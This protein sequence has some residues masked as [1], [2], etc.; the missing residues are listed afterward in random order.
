M[1]SETGRTLR[2]AFVASPGYEFI[3]ADYSQIE[4]RILAHL[5]RDPGLLGAFA[6]GEDI[7]TATAARVF[8]FAN[9]QVTPDLRRRAKAINFGLLYGM[10]AFGLADRLKISR[11]EA[12]EHMDTYFSQFP[13]VRRLP[14]V[15]GPGSPEERLHDHLVR[16]APLPSGTLL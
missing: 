15:G 2:R 8:G 10:A 13:A 9:D 6:A 5:S 4:L 16:S 1:R 14:P 7:H 11:E 12:R 3:V